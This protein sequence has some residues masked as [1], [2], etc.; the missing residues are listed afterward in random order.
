MGGRIVGF[1]LADEIVALWLAT[2]FEGGRHQRRIDQIAAPRIAERLKSPADLAPE[3]ETMPSPTLPIR[4]GARWPRPIRRS[5]RDPQDELQRQNDGLELIAS[6]NFVSQAVLEA[7]GSVLT[8]KYAEGYPGKRYYGGCEFVDVAEALAIARAKELFGAEHA[9]VQ[10]HSGA[11]ANMAVYFTLLKPGDTVLGM[12]LAH[13]GHLTHGHPLNFSGK[14]YT[15]VPYGVRQGRRADRL[16]R[17][18]AA[19]RTSTSRR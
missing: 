19:G 15:I 3:L 5:P 12:N 14:L 2:P 10:P 17:A 4:A 16:R 18:R 6:E 13:G 7:A 9:N 1:G 11:Q 8:N